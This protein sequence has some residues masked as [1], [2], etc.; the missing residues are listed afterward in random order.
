MIADYLTLADSLAAEI[1]GGRLA[2]GDRL[3]PQRDF[4][5]QHGIAAST[6]SRVYAE[7]RRRGLIS[8]E[9]GRGTYVRSALAQPHP[10]LTEP[11]PAPLD[12]ELNFPLLPDQNQ[13]IA[14]ALH[15]ALRPD[16]LHHALKAI[17][18]TATP[19]AR[20]IAAPFLARG[21]WQPA[22]DSL[23]FTGNGRQ[24]IAAALAAIASPGE[25][26]GAEALTYPA[27]QSIAAQLGITVIP[28][29]MDQYGVLPEAIAQHQQAAPL[30][31]LYLQPCLH[32]PLGISMNPA[33]KQAIA[34]LLH[35]TGLP[36]IED[37]TY[38]FLTD[39]APL[40]AFAPQQVIYVESFSKRIAPGLTLGIV[41][42]PSAIAPRLH[43]CIRA[44]GWSAAGVPLAVALQMIGDGT[45]ETISREK[46]QDAYD[47]QAIARH[48]LAGLPLKADSRAYHVWLEL[49]SG[50]R[51]ETL[52]E[53][54]ARHGIALL[55]ASAFTLSGHHAPPAVRL[56]LSAPPLDQ[57]RAG[58]E[59]LRRLMATATDCPSGSTPSPAGQ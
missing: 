30:K 53:T 33:R 4:A 2:P 46:R 32:N 47:R 25:R 10:A 27:L 13:T 51:A 16:T 43:H 57:L 29:A 59:T 58:L 28:L 9:V 35:A 41:S 31:G 5:Y 36:A 38:G 22:V 1:A 3:P 24:G 26:I 14:A 12:L 19:Q 18:A 42:A 15:R 56:A 7:L 49:P 23:A 17:G 21:G 20:A 39:D 11:S 6:A 34:D 8:G 45:A 44:G 52:V 40:A 37:A 55:P 50:W 54:A 48:C